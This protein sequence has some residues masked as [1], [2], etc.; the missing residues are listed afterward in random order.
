MK[1]NSIKFKGIKFLL[2]VIIIYIII[3][4]FE[5][6]NFILALYKSF[7]ILLNLLPIFVIIIIITTIINFFLKPKKIMKYFGKDSGVKGWIYAVL[8]GVISHG[9]MY[10]WYPMISELREN[11]LKDGLLATFMFSR[12]IKI[13][14][15][16]IMIDYFGILFTMIFFT[17]I[18]ITS[19]LQGLLIEA[20]NKKR[21]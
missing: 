6:E 5:K 21:F 17:S 13:P 14:F 16:P 2:F 19:I 7:S 20:L 10:A 1:K 3:A 4:L 15:V 8:G 12:T 18:L 11:G 9:P